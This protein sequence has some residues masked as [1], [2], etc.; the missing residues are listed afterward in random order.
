VSSITV[1]TLSKAGGGRR[2]LGANTMAKFEGLII[3]T[4]D[5]AATLVKKATR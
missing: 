5:F 1:E 3:F 4:L 2:R